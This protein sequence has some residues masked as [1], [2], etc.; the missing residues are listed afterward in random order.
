MVVF[1]V[2]DGHDYK[3]SFKKQLYDTTD[4]EIRI[5]MSHRD[6]DRL[7][8]VCRLSAETKCRPKVQRHSAFPGCG[9]QM[10]STKCSCCP[11]ASLA[12]VCAGDKLDGS[13]WRKATALR[14]MEQL[15]TAVVVETKPHSSLTKEDTLHFESATQ[16]KTT[17]RKKC[18]NCATNSDNR[19]QDCFLG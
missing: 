7:S 6:T 1:C 12:G 9:I 2:T 17:I 8:A 13:V 4:I 16:P 15:S 3:C 10:E 18:T 11:I 19:Q 5:E 14:Q